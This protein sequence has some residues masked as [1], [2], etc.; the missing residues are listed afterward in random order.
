MDL[1]SQLS[2][3]NPPAPKIEIKLKPQQKVYEPLVNKEFTVGHPKLGEAILLEDIHSKMNKGLYGIKGESCKIIANAG[4][5][6]LV[7]EGMNGRFHVKRE[8]VKI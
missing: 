4:G 5:P 8:Q 7:L 6:L 3:Y 2:D 1:F